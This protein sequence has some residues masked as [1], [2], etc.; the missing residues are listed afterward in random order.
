MQSVLT[1]DIQ[2]DVHSPPNTFQCVA[3]QNA[4]HFSAQFWS[5]FRTCI[6]DVLSWVLKISWSIVI[7]HAVFEDTHRKNPS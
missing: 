4:A 1:T 3:E 5:D 6:N 7:I 2:N